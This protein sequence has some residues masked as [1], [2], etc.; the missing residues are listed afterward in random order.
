MYASVTQNGIQYLSFLSKIEDCLVDL[1]ILRWLK[2]SMM[3]YK[4]SMNLIFH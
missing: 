1:M 2:T 3:Y 4:I